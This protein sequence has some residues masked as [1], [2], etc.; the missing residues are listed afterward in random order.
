M[1]LFLSFFSRSSL[2]L[3]LFLC[4]YPTRLSFIVS[5]FHST[6]QSPSLSLHNITLFIILSILD[7]SFFLNQLINRKYLSNFLPLST[8]LPVKVLCVYLSILFYI[9]QATYL[10]PECLSIK[11][12]QSFFTSMYFV[13]NKP[14]PSSIYFLSSY[15]YILYLFIYLSISF[16]IMYL[17][18]DPSIYLSVCLLPICLFISFLY[19]SFYLSICNCIYLPSTM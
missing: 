9:Y 11:F 4:F 14:L 8:F 16:N 12:C 15:L 3:I 17:L 18:V 7:C 13:F 5:L 19:L 10:Q 6:P 1:F 2:S